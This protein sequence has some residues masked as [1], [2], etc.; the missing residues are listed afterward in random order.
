MEHFYNNIQGWSDGIDILY[1]KMVKA[2]PSGEMV[3]NG[4]GFAPAST[5]PYHF[6]EVGTWKGKSAAFMAVE[7]KN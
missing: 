6:V 3:F 4:D 1:Q 7:I 2:V 5:R